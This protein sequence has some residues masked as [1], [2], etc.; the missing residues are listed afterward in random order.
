MEPSVNK[1]IMFLADKC[2]LSK[3]KG[4]KLSKYVAKIRIDILRNEVVHGRTN[5][6]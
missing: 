4:R 1:Y 6:V 3:E 5:K 2:I